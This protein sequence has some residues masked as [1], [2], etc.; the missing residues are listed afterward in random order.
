M[1]QDPA[2][3]PKR[4]DGPIHKTRTIHAP[5]PAVRRASVRID[6]LRRWF[7]ADA[8]IKAERAF[9]VSWPG[10]PVQGRFLLWS[11]HAV[12]MRWEDPVD[13]SRVTIGFEPHPDHADATLLTFTHDTLEGHPTLRERYDVWWDHYLDN[14]VAWCEARQRNLSPQLDVSVGFKAIGFDLPVEQVIPRPLRK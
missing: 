12:Q 6:A 4:D 11:D 9:T 3:K 14:L 10:W 2:S 13:V 1:T 5:T 8:T 7:A